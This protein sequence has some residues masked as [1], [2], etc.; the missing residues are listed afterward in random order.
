[1]RGLYLVI[2]AW[3]ATL[4][5][6]SAYVGVVDPPQDP[7]AAAVAPVTPR[8]V[9][10]RYCVSCHNER[11]RTAGLT[12]DALDD[13]NVGA[14][15]ETWE[16]VVRKLR[17]R[18]MPPAGSIRPDEATYDAVAS[19]LEGDLDRLAAAAPNPG[20]LPAFRRLTRTE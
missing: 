9:L 17:S 10:N 19:R 1:M 14:A 15:P 7:P 13:R 6:V 18:A 5:A 3:M 12:L 4:T 11:L 20:T 8:A 2:A 16:K